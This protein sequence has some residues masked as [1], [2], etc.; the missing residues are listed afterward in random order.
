MY[1]G[2]AILSTHVCKKSHH[3][4]PDERRVMRGATISAIL[5]LNL[6]NPGYRIFKFFCILLQVVSM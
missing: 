6:L 3:T 4:I 5:R 2:C 1:E